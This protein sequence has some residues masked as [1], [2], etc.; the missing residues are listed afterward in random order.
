LD[1]LVVDTPPVDGPELITFNRLGLT[2]LFKVDSEPSLVAN[3]GQALHHLTALDTV[4]P[5]RYDYDLR[6]AQV[7]A[8]QGRTAAAQRLFEKARAS[9]GAQPEALTET[10]H[11]LQLVNE[12]NGAPDIPTYPLNEAFGVPSQLRLLAAGLPD[13]ATAGDTIPLALAWQ[14]LGHIDQ[15]YT[16]FVHLRAPSGQTVAQLDFQPFDGAFPTSHWPLGQTI[17]ETRLWTLPAN[18]PRG[19]Y[20]LVTGLYQVDTLTRL[21][22]SGSGEGSDEVRLGRV[23][24]R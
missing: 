1:I 7:L 8:Y 20:I 21:P 15:D 11:A 16:V 17:E 23:W 6:R 19:P 13:S 2:H 5:D 4:S 3:L 18:L 22:V 14:A 24:L 12:L 10:A 9:P